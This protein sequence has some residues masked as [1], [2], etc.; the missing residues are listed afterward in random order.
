[1]K[2]KSI[3]ILMSNNQAY[4]DYVHAIQEKHNCTFRQA[5]KKAKKSHK[6]KPKKQVDNFKPLFKIVMGVR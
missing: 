6:P 4:Y 5:Q 3:H 2:Q 1:M